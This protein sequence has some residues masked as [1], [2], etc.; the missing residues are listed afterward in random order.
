M[1]QR[2]RHPFRH[3]VAAPTA[4]GRHRNNAVVTDGRTGDQ[5]RHR[6]CKVHLHL[7]PEQPGRHL[8]AKFHRRPAF[9]F[10]FGAEDGAADDALVPVGRSRPVQ[11]A[12]IVAARVQSHDRG[13]GRSS[14]S[15]GVHTSQNGSV[16]ST[17]RQQGHR[18]GKSSWRI[19]RASR[20]GRAVVACHQSF[21]TATM[22]RTFL[23][24]AQ[25]KL[26]YQPVR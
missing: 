3:I 15:R 19:C 21:L 17:L 11:S 26:S 7:C 10:V 20:A 6:L 5:P 13:R 2:L 22:M 14:S 23:P 16:P 25:P 8:H 9:A 18:L 12:Q 24:A 4:G 1:G